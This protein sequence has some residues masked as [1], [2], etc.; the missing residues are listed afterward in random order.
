[1][2]RWWL[3]GLLL[4]MA[5]SPAILPLYQILHWGIDVPYWDQWDKDFAGIYVKAHQG[6]LTFSDLAAQHNEHR[7]LV[8]R[9]AFLAIDSLSHGNVVVEM[10]VQ[11]LVVCVISGLIFW[12]HHINSPDSKNGIF[13]WFLA[14]LVIFSPTQMEN[15]LWGIGLINVMP[16]LF[17]LAA[18]LSARSGLGL[19]VRT[20]L[21]ITLSAAATWTSG[22]GVLSWVLAGM[23]LL[24]SDSWQEL[25]SKRWI[26]AALVAGFVL[27]VAL[28]FTGYTSPGPSGDAS[29][30]RGL[31]VFV[32]YLLL[33]AGSLFSLCSHFS[34][35]TN[36]SACGLLML[37]LLAGGLVHFAYA[38][39]WRRDL[40][41]CRRLLVWY[42]VA[43]Y[44]VLNGMIIAAAR[45]GLGTDS[46]LSSRYIAFSVYLPIALVF[47]IPMISWDLASRF[48]GI[49]IFR[50]AL[51]TLLIVGWI[52][53]L[54]QAMQMSQNMSSAR[55]ATKASVLLVK[56]LPNNPMI[57]SLVFPQPKVVQDYAPVLNQMGYLHPPLIESNNV[58][59]LRPADAPSNAIA[60]QFERAFESGKAN[61]TLTGWAISPRHHRPADGVLLCYNNDKGEPT[62]F[63]LAAVRIAREDRPEV[64]KDRAYRVC[65]WGVELP[66][67]DLPPW[68]R[69]LFITAWALEVD[70]GKAYPLEGSITIPR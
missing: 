66:V 14:N 28:Y 36:A 70:T 41:F 61:I 25:K 63:A 58:S 19:W 51:A 55:R 9:V 49:Q 34:I 8:P 5:I 59:L 42:A 4:L 21:V 17:T 64:Q 7:P 69:S 65:G 13:L 11:W 43:G 24:W 56:V 60:G 68:P 1:M 54:P 62:I 23:V 52:L 27:N 38:W 48:R 50:P 20:A 10:I 26:G 30:P 31:L 2:K 3:R 33:Y 37:L 6:Q 40:E 15:W 53:G 12:L 46:A 45:V 16:A 35:Q 57:S 32:N 39:R 29:Q 22:S 47:L 67:A 44:A 18:I